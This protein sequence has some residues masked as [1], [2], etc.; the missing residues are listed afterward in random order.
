MRYCRP[1][2]QLSFQRARS[3]EKKRQRAEALMEAA[4][5]VAQENGVASVTLTAVAG[6]AGVHYS[7]VRRYFSSHKEVLLR[8]AVQGWQRWAEHVC[9]ALQSP[10]PAS[11]ARVSR[12][13]ADGLAADP[14][15]CDLLSNLHLHL[16]HEVDLDRVVEVKRDST[17]AGLRIVAEVHRALPGLTE[18]NALDLV[19]AAHSLA[20]TLWQLANPPEGLADAYALDP[21]VPPDWNLDFRTALTRLLTATCI[22]LLD[23]SD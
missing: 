6:R 14:L 21:E 3:E 12:A 22:G 18:Q 23:Q 16:E 7:A 5:F 9:T 4:R 10:G 20:A 15:F 19:L 8:L 17:A 13:L 11:P 2:R 1:V